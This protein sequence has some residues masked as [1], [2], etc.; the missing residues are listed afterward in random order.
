MQVVQA[1]ALIRINKEAFRYIQQ[2][3]KTDLPI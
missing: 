3:C 2:I 1:Q